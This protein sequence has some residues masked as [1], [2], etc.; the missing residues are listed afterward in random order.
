MNYAVVK[1]HL[2][3]LDGQM[4]SKQFTFHP[5]TQIHCFKITPSQPIKPHF[6][7]THDTVLDPWLQSD[8]LQQILFVFLPFKTKLYS[9]T[10]EYIGSDLCCH[11]IPVYSIYNIFLTIYVFLSSLHSCPMFQDHSKPT[12]ENPVYCV[13]WHCSWPLVTKSPVATNIAC[14]TYFKK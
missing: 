13:T 4:Y 10:Y 3:M 8:P 12:N 11:L 7:M 9:F 5:N 1:S 6:N 2:S 14:K